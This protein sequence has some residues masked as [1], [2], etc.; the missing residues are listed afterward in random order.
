[1]KDL[2]VKVMEEFTQLLEKRLALRVLTTEDSV[3]YTLFAALLANGVSPEQTVMEYPHPSLPGA[4]IDTVI[5]S[6]SQTLQ[7]AIEFKYDRTIPS[8]ENQPRSQKAGAV[9]GD[10]VRLL[11][12][13]S[14]CLRYF[15]YATDGE[16]ARYFASPRNGLS[17]FFGLAKGATLVLEEKYFSGQSRTFHESMGNWP[18]RAVVYGVASE[19]LPQDHHLRVYETEP[20][21]A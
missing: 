21:A 1:M 4:E 3:R 9:F 7:M 8:K 20:L 5:L 13:P 15:V 6:A 16:L 14:P 11:K 18:C 10:L 19:Q 12:I 17:G 2:M